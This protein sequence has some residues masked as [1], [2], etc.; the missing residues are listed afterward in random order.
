[1]KTQMHDGKRNKN[2]GGHTNMN[3]NMKKLASL[4]GSAFLVLGLLLVNVG[5]VHALYSDTISSNNAAAMVV[6]ITPNADR[7]VQISTGNV[8]LDLG[9]VE[10]G[11]ST[12]TVNPATVTIQG[13]MI[14]NELDLSAS[15]TGG[16]VFDQNQTRTSTGTN[17]L[18]VWATFTSISTG[19]APTTQGDEYFRVGSST[20]TKLAV[21]GNSFPATTV[22][23]TPGSGIG[24]FENNEG[25]TGPSGADMD[26]MSPGDV[27]HLFTYF[28]LP[29]TTSI[30]GPQDIN[31]VLSLRA[32]P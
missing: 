17:Q 29:P 31:F 3:K 19:L 15:I 23:V 12:Q 10:L 16:W 20:S 6:R 27:R 8:G 14:E 32:G 7:G 30:T 4:A 21:A 5:K 11:A 18:N 2:K 13:N 24:K 22:G 1:M 25:G 28:R 9:T 26:S